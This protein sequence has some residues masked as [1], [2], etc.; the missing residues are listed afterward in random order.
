MDGAPSL[1]KNCL[2]AVSFGKTLSQSM[3][4]VWED[5]ALAVDPLAAQALDKRKGD[6]KHRSDEA[7]SSG[8]SA[9]TGDG[10]AEDLRPFVALLRRQHA[11]CTQGE[12]L[13]AAVTEEP[14]IESRATGTHLY[15]PLLGCLLSDSP[16][17][18]G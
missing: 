17:V 1:P 16:R 12:G 7:V 15:T 6:G 13:A 14:G 11:R 4:R 2:P 3:G 9:H 5:Q 8:R 10:L 18:N